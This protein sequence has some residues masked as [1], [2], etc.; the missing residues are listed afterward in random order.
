MSWRRLHVYNLEKQILIYINNLKNKNIRNNSRKNGRSILSV[1]EMPLMFLLNEGYSNLLYLLFFRIVNYLGNLYSQRCFLSWIWVYT[2]WVTLVTNNRS[3]SSLRK[4]P[5]IY[6]PDRVGE[7]G[8]FH[9][10]G[11]I[12]LV[13]SPVI[14]SF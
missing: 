3:H 4:C 9:T 12:L 14:V 5:S 6:L 13:V 7:P 10:W 1:I 8:M 2:I 11:N